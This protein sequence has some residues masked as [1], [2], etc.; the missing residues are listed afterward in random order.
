MDQ[1]DLDG[2]LAR[3]SLKLHCFKFNIEY[4]KGSQNTV[5]DALSRVNAVDEILSVSDLNPLNVDLDSAAFSD[6]EY[7]ERIVKKIPA[8]VAT[9]L[10]EQDGRL[11]ISPSFGSKVANSDLPEWKLFI[12]LAFGSDVDET[13]A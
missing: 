9:N 11:F 6:P 13:S 10:R 2:R 12:P 8:N 4:R 1:K 3:W 7:L 5:P